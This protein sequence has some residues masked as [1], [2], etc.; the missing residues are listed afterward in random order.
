VNGDVIAAS[1]N[2]ELFGIAV[3]VLAGLFF[4]VGGLIPPT[5]A[6][7]ETPLLLLPGG[8]RV[9]S[10]PLPYRWAW[11]DKVGAWAADVSGWG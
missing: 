2:G 4:T 11:P 10:S 5:A 7:A 1:D 6:A 9:R 8:G 3:V